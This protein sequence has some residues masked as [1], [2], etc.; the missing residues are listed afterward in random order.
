MI[1]LPEHKLHEKAI[2]SELALF[3]LPET[4]LSRSGRLYQVSILHKGRLLLVHSVPTASRGWQLYYFELLRGSH[5]AGSKLN[6]T[7]RVS[8]RWGNSNL[9]LSC[10]GL[11]SLF[12]LNS[13]KLNSPKVTRHENTKSSNLNQY[14]PVFVTFFRTSTAECNHPF[15]RRELMRQKRQLH[16]LNF[17]LNNY[18]VTLLYSV[19]AIRN[20]NC[21]GTIFGQNI[22]NNLCKSN[23]I[24]IDFAN[25]TSKYPLGILLLIYLIHVQIMGRN[26]YIF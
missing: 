7:L 3:K 11:S 18:V 2:G 23:R 9:P 21:T 15:C 8:V 6:L 12:V 17:C 10:A 25:S 4:N 24:V 20:S 5:S 16:F 13:K 1:T 26:F 19:G 22:S 14:L